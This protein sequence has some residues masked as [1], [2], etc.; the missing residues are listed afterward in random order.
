[1]HPLKNKT[2]KTKVQNMMA[3]LLSMGFFK[4]E[5]YSYICFKKNRIANLET[6]IILISKPKFLKLQTKDTQVLKW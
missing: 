3:E 1:M 4:T 2:L 5:S 6:N